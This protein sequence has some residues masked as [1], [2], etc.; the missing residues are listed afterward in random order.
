LS[1]GGALGPTHPRAAGT[2]EIT[3]FSVQNDGKS[4]PEAGPYSQLQL[5]PTVAVYEDMGAY[6]TFTE[7]MNH[8]TNAFG[9]A[10]T[11]GEWNG[12]G[13]YVYGD[14]RTA[15]NAAGAPPL[16]STTLAA[17]HGNAVPAQAGVGA[18]VAAAPIVARAAIVAAAAAPFSGADMIF[19]MKLIKPIVPTTMS[20]FNIRLRLLCTVPGME[21]VLVAATSKTLQLPFS[22]AGELAGVDVVNA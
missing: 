22:A 15:A 6:R 5:V 18:V 17:V 21:L 12:T 2:F 20:R 4:Y 7:S 19:G 13:D 1:L 8:K 11:F 10:V 9:T 3:E 14:V 16:G